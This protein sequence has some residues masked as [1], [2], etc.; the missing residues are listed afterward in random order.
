MS[1]ESAKS[2]RRL[3]E[4]GGQLLGLFPGCWR[5]F[6][7]WCVFLQRALEEES[8]C[9]VFFGEVPGGWLEREEKKLVLARERKVRET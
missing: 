7:R 1:K 8:F 4:R 5:F 2:C 6:Q 3:E 9:L